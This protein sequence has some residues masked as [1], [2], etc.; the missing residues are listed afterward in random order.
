MDRIAIAILLFYAGVRV[1]GALGTV[2]PF[3]ALFGFL[4]FLA[5]IYLLIRMVPW[6][7]TKVMWPLRNRLIVAY[8]FIA[9]V[10]VILLLTMV[11]V[12]SY[13]LY[14]ELGAHLLHDDLQDRISMV[15][16]ETKAI[17]SEI[18][19]EAGTES[20]SVDE[21]VLKRPNVANLIAGAE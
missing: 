12:G 1:L 17:S 20:S 8:V 9:V 7:R 14:L 21:S 6:F 5:I 19:R 10:P 2:V 11:G 3:S 13:L 4:A 16:E 15:S 18:E